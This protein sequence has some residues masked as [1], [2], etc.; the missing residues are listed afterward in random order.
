MM[1][2]H[3]LGHHLQQL[4]DFSIWLFPQMSSYFSDL[5]QITSFNSSYGHTQPF[6]Q[7]TPK[8]GHHHHNWPH[9]RDPSRF[10]TL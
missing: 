1:V 7:K 8:I 2:L 5:V 6:G 10:Q 3:L 9:N 4:P